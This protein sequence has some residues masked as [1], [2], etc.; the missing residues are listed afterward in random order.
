M[1]EIIVQT[2]PFNTG[3]AG[4]IDTITNPHH[5][6]GRSHLHQCVAAHRSDI[7]PEP[8]VMLGVR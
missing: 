1:T 2:N 4:V 3:V 6:Y 8:P 5:L 7:V